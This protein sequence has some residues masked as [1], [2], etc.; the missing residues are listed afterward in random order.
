MSRLRYVS[1][2]TLAV[3]LSC[4]PA[5]EG[6]IREAVM[7]YASF[8][9][10][11]AA[12]IGAYPEPSRGPAAESF[13]PGAHGRALRIENPD[14]GA[15]LAYRAEGN[16]PDPGSAWSGTLT[17][18][19]RAE[20]GAAADKVQT[21]V[22]IANECSAPDGLWVDYVGGPAP[23]LRLGAVTAGG[24]PERSGPAVVARLRRLKGGDWRHVAVTWAN[25]DSGRGNAWA[26]LY[27]D[28]DM[29]GTVTNATFRSGRQADGGFLCV[30]VNFRGAIDELAVL[31][32]PLS[33]KEVRRLSAEPAL[34]AA[35]KGSGS[36]DAAAVF[37]FRSLARR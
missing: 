14:G 35:L 31:S 32:R 22:R 24:E 5:A 7:F 11:A 19:L 4:T 2:P 27:L 15:A 33:Q 6:P 13:E 16:L 18:W 20:P 12:D 25:F 34:L 36:G 10:R 8:D 9:E 28:G 3:M 26:A 29:A 30:G 21:P 17:F 37:E 23:E 1:V